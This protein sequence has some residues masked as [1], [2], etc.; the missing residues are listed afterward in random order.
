MADNPNQVPDGSD[1]V[2]ADRG[3]AFKKGLLDALSC[4]QTPGSFASFARLADPPPAGLTVNG[5][6]PITM[7]L[8]QSQ[9]EQ[10]VAAARQAP[11]GKGSETIVDTSVRN[12]WE[13]DATQFA[14]EN[15]A[16]PGYLGWLCRHV[17]QQLG[18][19]APIRAEPYKMLF[20]EKIPSMFGTLIICLPSAHQ[21]G[22]VVLRHCGQKEVFKTSEAPQ[23]FICWY[24]DVSH[25]VLPVTS[26]IRWVLTYN[27]ALDASA[28]A[29]RTSAS[30]QQLETQAL[31]AALQRW[32]AEDK[33]SRPKPFIYHTLD[34]EYTEANT[35]LKAL[36]TRDLAQV[37]ALLRHMSAKR[38]RNTWATR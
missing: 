29:A 17:A 12:T 22:E 16:W 37:Q 25:E 27:L 15:P 5:I 30:L 34:H 18:I 23:S 21:G 26:G 14:F 4:I 35:S 24:S 20:T 36:K 19:G 6:G 3:K 8:S 2:R 11:Y 32:L 1:A 33:D 31:D 13:L 38:S 9:A 7:P 28:H 10:L